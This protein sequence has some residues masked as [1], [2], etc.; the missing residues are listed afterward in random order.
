MTRLGY[1]TSTG[2]PLR[3]PN[4][5]PLWAGGASTPA[6]SE[7]GC[8]WNGYNG[9]SEQSRH[10]RRPV[11]DV[12]PVGFFKLPASGNGKAESGPERPE[13]LSFLTNDD[14]ASGSSNCNEKDRHFYAHSPQTSSAARV[15]SYLSRMEIS[16][17]AKLGLKSALAS[18]WSGKR[19]GE[20]ARSWPP[21]PDSREHCRM[22]SG[23]VRA[24]TTRESYDTG[25]EK[26]EKI[27]QTFACPFYRRNPKEY[28][29][30]L[31][32]PTIQGIP[33]LIQHLW[34]VHCQPPYCPTCQA[35]FNSTALCDE[36]ITSRRC[37]PRGSLRTK[38]LT[39][40]QMQQLSEIEELAEEHHAWMAPGVQWFLIW[41]IVF[42]GEEPLLRPYLSGKLESMICAARKF[43]LRNG[44]RIILD[45]L[46]KRGYQTSREMMSDER[47]LTTLHQAVLGQ[48]VDQLIGSHAQ[49]DG[50][51]VKGC[52]QAARP[53]VSLEVPSPYTMA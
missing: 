11:R 37:I 46:G 7:V 10:I 50:S 44:Q 26:T 42:P 6:S 36:H 53:M 17:L 47:N 27:S 32:D 28:E 9:Y 40:E 51:N 25:F 49:G 23:K 48:M 5:E 16:A 4:A 33:S 38:G 18:M 29:S 21:S 30:C 41:S 12:S 31:R 22:A 8:E 2:Q 20:R 3:V 14:S 43:W 45:F 52:S 1:G 19:V 13:Q 15:P 24:E 39:Q 35:T 34:D